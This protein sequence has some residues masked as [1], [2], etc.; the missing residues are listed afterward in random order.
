MFHAAT[1]RSKSRNSSGGTKNRGTMRSSYLKTKMPERRLTR[2][3]AS[4]TL[5]ILS[6]YLIFCR[7]RRGSAGHFMSQIRGWISILPKFNQKAL[8]IK[9]KM[10]AIWLKSR[11]N[12]SPRLLRRTTSRYPLKS[13]HPCNPTKSQNWS[14]ST[15]SK[16]I[17]TK[18]SNKITKLKFKRVKKLEMA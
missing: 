2:D 12:N 1:R 10:L 5:D 3:T 16:L 7:R 6:T 14:P 4:S 13:S 11:R 18:S 17:M 8:K 15:R 9:T